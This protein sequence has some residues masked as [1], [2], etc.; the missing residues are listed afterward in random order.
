MGLLFTSGAGMVGA[1]PDAA[2]P[3]TH[4][5][6]PW[7]DRLHPSGHL[8]PLRSRDWLAPGS[9]SKREQGFLRIGTIAACLDLRA[10]IHWRQPWRPGGDGHGGVRREVRDHDQSL[11]LG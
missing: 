6:R 4:A 7:V 10:R 5:S 9:H 11:L 2:T 1:F 8:L 3:D